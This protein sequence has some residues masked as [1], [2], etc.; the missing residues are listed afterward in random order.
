MKLSLLLS[1]QIE[2]MPMLCDVFLLLM[3]KEVQKLNELKQTSKKK[4]NKVMLLI[5]AVS[6]RK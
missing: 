6:A 5:V 4:I 1:T 2:V 3:K